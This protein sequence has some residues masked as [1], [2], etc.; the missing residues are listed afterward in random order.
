MAVKIKIC[1]LKRPED[2]EYV[3]EC[4]PDYTGF[5]FFPLS[6]RYVTVEKAKE[7]KQGLSP[8]IIPVGVFLDN[9][10]EEIL[11]VAESRTA[12][13]LQ[14]HGKTAPALVRKLKETVTLPVWEAVPISS[15]ADMQRIETSPADMVLLDHG[16]GGTGEI[17]DWS[18]LG[19]I[20]REFFLAGG[21]NASNI[22]EALKCKPYGVDVSSGVET[23]KMK[24]RDKIKEF[25]QIVR[26]EEEDNG[27]V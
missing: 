15:E 16:Q 11:E 8:G 7:L 9:T 5:V 4:R 18:L 12:Q 17:F 23:N 25:I 13:I 24:D 2:I 10:L 19:N 27:N 6:S 26:S 20:R 3:N 14:L 1:G 22:R 21:L